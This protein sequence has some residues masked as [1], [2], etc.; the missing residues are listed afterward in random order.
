LPDGADL[1]G[2]DDRE[3]MPDEREDILD[4]EDPLDE[5]DWDMLGPEPERPPEWP[6][7]PPERP[8]PPPLPKTDIT[9]RKNTASAMIKKTKCLNP[10]FPIIIPLTTANIIPSYYTL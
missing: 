3:D 10:F 8:P 7:D 6:P 4:C 2:P 1:D 9:G 5:L